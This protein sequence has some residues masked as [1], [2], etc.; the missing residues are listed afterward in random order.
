MRFWPNTA[1]SRREKWLSIGSDNSM[2]GSSQQP[3]FY[4]LQVDTHSKNLFEQ[5]QLISEISQLDS[6]REF[7]NDS[8]MQVVMCS[9]SPLKLPQKKI[10]VHSKWNCPIN[11]AFDRSWWTEEF[12]YI[13]MVA[14]KMHSYCRPLET[15]RNILWGR[16]FVVFCLSFIARVQLARNWV[17][18]FGSGSPECH[19][20]LSC[21]WRPVRFRHTNTIHFFVTGRPSAFIYAKH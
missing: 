14:I 2:V 7:I 20:K 8:Q 6:G 19:N 4:S 15:A 17:N 10:T 13:Q 3:R 12:F 18:L 5:I 9:R 1:L 16:N 11:S 21:M